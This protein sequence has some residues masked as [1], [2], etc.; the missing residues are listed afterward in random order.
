M[1]VHLVFLAACNQGEELQEVLEDQPVGGGKEEHQQL[2]A[3]GGGG[4][5]GEGWGERKWIQSSCR[6]AR[7]MWMLVHNIL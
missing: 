4:R 7:M 3:A 2:Q 6:P 1:Y 5:G